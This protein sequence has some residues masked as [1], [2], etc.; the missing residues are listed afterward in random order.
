[1]SYQKE[2]HELGTA[3]L[4]PF[5]FIF[6]FALLFVL[7]NCTVQHKMSHNRAVKSKFHR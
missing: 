5:V 3:R 4:L 2:T 1:M 7:S 6:F